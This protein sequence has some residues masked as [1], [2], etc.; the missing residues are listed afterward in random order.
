MKF[1]VLAT[2]GHKGKVIEMNTDQEV[3]TLHSATGD[4]LGAL[5]W[6][7]V[8]EQI[9]ASDDDVR[10]A[11]MRSHPRAPL[12]LK[13]HYTTQEGAQFESLTSG[14][15]AGGLFIESSA[16]LA[17]GTELSVE[18]SLPDHPWAKYKAKAKVA[19]TRNK[20]ERHLLFP[21]M[22]IQFTDI[23]EKARKELIELVDALNRSR[24]GT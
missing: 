2:E 22:G 17:P 7:A 21:G 16:P 1:S 10:Y 15:G 14:I 8:I 6:G 11:H 5:S 13:V 12:A 24:L 18:F 3:V 9:L 19:W 4:L 23:D 20:P